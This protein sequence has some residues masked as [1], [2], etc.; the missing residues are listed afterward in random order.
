MDLLDSASLPWSYRLL[1]AGVV[2]S[3]YVL[4]SSFASFWRL[5]HIPGPPLA[6]VSQLWLIRV[7]AQGRLYLAAEDAFK[8]YGNSANS[9]SKLE[10]AIDESRLDISGRTKYDPYE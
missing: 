10:R 4:V 6:C 2:L 1:A 8:R 5:R 7:T 9:G 3:F